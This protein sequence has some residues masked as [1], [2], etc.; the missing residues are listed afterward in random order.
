MKQMLFFY[1]NSSKEEEEK[2]KIHRPYDWTFSTDFR[3]KIENT[4]CFNFSI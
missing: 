3:G 1:F 4:V 2:K